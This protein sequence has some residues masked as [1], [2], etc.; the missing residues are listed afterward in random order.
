MLKCAEEG[1]K[2]LTKAQKKLIA[3]PVEKLNSWDY[4]YRT[5]SVEAAIF[6]AWEFMIA[7]YMHEAKIED[8][9]LRRSLWSIGDSQ[10]FFYRQVNDWI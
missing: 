4:Q 3:K 7:T 8:I 5:T 6:D 9:R 10:M 2:T 1:S